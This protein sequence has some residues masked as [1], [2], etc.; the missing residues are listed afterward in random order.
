MIVP[1]LKP[2]HAADLIDCVFFWGTAESGQQP[3][4]LDQ[5]GALQTGGEAAS[6]PALP[7]SQSPAKSHLAAL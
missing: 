6:S 2:P 3:T 7:F 5:H 1:L 4:P